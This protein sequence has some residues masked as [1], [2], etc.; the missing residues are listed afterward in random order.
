M[1]PK[2]ANRRQ[3]RS[4]RQSPPAE[5]MTE[6]AW[7]R[8]S[9]ERLPDGPCKV[10]VADFCEEARRGGASVEEAMVQ[11]LAY[12]QRLWPEEVVLWSLDRGL[13]PDP[14]HDESLQRGVVSSLLALR[15]LRAQYV[16]ATV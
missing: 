1:A 6:G 15:E 5:A 9:F 12:A 3:R 8:D 14:W 2:V 16:T 7:A 11:G 13:V 10:A 4:E